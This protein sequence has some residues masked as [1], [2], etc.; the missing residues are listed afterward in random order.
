MSEKVKVISFLGITNY[1]LTRYVWKG[2]EVETEFFPEAVAHFIRPDK[3]MV[4]LTPTAQAGEKSTNWQELQ[5]RFERDNIPYEPLPIPEG[6]TE[7]DLW[8]IFNIL[9]NAVG[10]GEKLVFDITN[11]F[12]SLPFLSFLAIAYLKAAKNVRVESVLYGAWEAKDAEN[13]SPVFDLT[14]F[15]S[16][17]DWLTAT[18]QFVQTGNARFLSI[19]MNPKNEKTGALSEAASTL[20]VISQAARLCQPFT[21]MQEVVQ[22]EPTLN[23]AQSVLEFNTTPFNVLK[24][25]IVNTFGQFECHNSEVTEETLRKEFRLINW[26]YEKGQVMQAISLAREWLIDVVTFRLGEKINFAMDY[27]KPFEEAIAGIALVGKPHP[28]DPQRNFTQD[29]LNRYGSKI[30]EWEERELLRQLWT[31]LKNVRNRLDHAEHHP[32]KPK[33]RTLSALEKLQKKMDE[34]VMKSLRQLAVK[35]NLAEEGVA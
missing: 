10:E 16:L 8:Q 11:S 29:D 21:L 7:A 30:W 14:P 26:Y 1:K 15:V 32:K 3:I 27:R 34:K 33:E 31:D 35:W 5:R 18:E 4:C 12:R 20:K 17:L 24:S 6:H 9:T 13:R 22:L 19:L 28:Q 23:N 2:R 25:E